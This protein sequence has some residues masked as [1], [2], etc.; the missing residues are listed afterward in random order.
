MAL[1]SWLRLLLFSL[2]VAVDQSRRGFSPITYDG[3]FEQLQEW[4]STNSELI[5]VYTAREKYNLFLPDRIKCSQMYGNCEHHIVILTNHTSWD[6]DPSR[7]HVF[8]SGALHGNER[9]GPT[10][11]IELTRYLLSTHSSSE[12]ISYLLNHRV[13]I[14]TPMSNALG[15]ARSTRTEESLDPNRDF[16]FLKDASQ[17]MTTIVGRVLNEIF[18]EY[19]VQLA[20]T[21]HGGMRGIAY[22][23]GGPNQPVPM[24]YSPDHI[25]QHQM[26]QQMQVLGGHLTNWKNQWFYPIG[27]LNKVVY[28]VKGGME[29]WAYTGSW[30]KGNVHPCKPTTYNKDGI[31]PYPK[32]RTIYN[33]AQLRSFNFLI[34]SSEKH[35]PSEGYGSKDNS[36]D[37]IW[38][39]DDT[40][41]DGHIPRN[42]RISTFL[43]NSAQPYVMIKNSPKTIE[44]DVEKNIFIG[45]KGPLSIQWLVSGAMSVYD[46]D[47]VFTV[48][49]NEKPENWKVLRMQKDPDWRMTLFLGEGENVKKREWKFSMETETE[50]KLELLR[51]IAM[52]CNG[53]RHC[54]IWMNVRVK[55]D[56]Q[57][58]ENRDLKTGQI[59]KTYPQG[60]GPQSHVVNARNMNEDEWNMKNNKYFVKASEWWMAET[61]VR[62]D[63]TLHGGPPIKPILPVLIPA[64]DS[65]VFT[66]QI[67]AV[68][69][70]VV[71]SAVCCMVRG[72]KRRRIRR[73]SRINTYRRVPVWPHSV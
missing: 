35:T 70:A 31:A 66:L 64:D 13:I 8:F 19:L 48:N 29:D 59:V 69:C 55:V 26:A 56:D 54:P 1:T 68:L 17:C 62:I 53:V 61:P 23:W 32:E 49:E 12:W 43:I 72:R 7:P 73:S 16:P 36:W 46:Y 11:L 22:E 63:V 24:D 39:I 33:D 2:T 21:F 67:S 58:M 60:V 25:A 34:E 45:N 15:Y 6:S 14:M 52:K 38:N 51:Q 10:T 40:K 37:S 5:K 28:P 20:I 44:F 47:L 42:M 50:L 71:L 30:D 41:F 27:T 18:R 9:I 57:W 3:I 4:K 65:S